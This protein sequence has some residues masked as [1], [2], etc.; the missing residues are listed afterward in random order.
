MAPPGAALGDV[1]TVVKLVVG[2]VVVVDVSVFVGLP[3]SSEPHAVATGSITT[4]ATR[5]IHAEVLRFGARDFE[6][7][8]SPAVNVMSGSPPCRLVVL[9]FPDIANFNPQRPTFAMTG[10]PLSMPVSV[11]RG[12]D[13]DAGVCFLEALVRD[14][15]QTCTLVE[16]SERDCA[17]RRHGG[18][19]LGDGNRKSRTEISGVGH[20]AVDAFL[21]S[22]AAAWLFVALPVASAEGP[23]PQY[24]LT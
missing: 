18:L 4:P 7:V 11:E 20:V 9:V 17:A 14:Q 5:P 23:L 13:V 15:G 21:E 19:D 2:V 16:L 6:R 10:R 22:E 3:P 8:V 12:A 24:S 1:V